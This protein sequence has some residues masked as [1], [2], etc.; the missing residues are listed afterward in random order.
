MVKQ[1]LGLTSLVVRDYDEALEFFVGT[2]GF[3]L[4]ADRFISEQ[5]KRWVVV[6][7]AGSQG[8]ALL[9]ARAAGP[10]QTAIVR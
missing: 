4:I 6:A 8:S 3:N 5:H 9:L 1:T 2:S 10:K 7:P